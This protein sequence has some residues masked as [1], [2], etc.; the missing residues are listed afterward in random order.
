[1]GPLKCRK[2][3]KTLSCPFHLLFLLLVLLATRLVFVA[4]ARQFIVDYFAINVL[5]KKKQENLN[6]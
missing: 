3:I 2:T 4:C 1:M 5:Q 6:I